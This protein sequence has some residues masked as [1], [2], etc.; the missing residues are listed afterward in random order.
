M[1]HAVIKKRKVLSVIEEGK[2]INEHFRLMS[3]ASFPSELIKFTLCLWIMSSFGDSK[4][5][6]WVHIQQI[7]NGRPPTTSCP[8]TSQDCSLGAKGPV[9]RGLAWPVRPWKG[10]WHS[11]VC[12][13]RRRCSCWR[14]CSACPRTRRAGTGTSSPGGPAAAG[15]RATLAECYKNNNKKQ[16]THCHSPVTAHR[17]RQHKESEGSGFGAGEMAHTEYGTEI[18]RPDCLS[19]LLLWLSQ[20]W[21]S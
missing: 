11:R 13:C 1:E 15:T 20:P 19:V 2:H 7:S 16:H 21:L 4:S 6:P 5:S 10:K 14:S 9:I 18:R 8:L 17:L 12:C 3:K